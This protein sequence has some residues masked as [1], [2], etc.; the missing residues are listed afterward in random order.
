MKTLKYFLL[1]AI[2]GWLSSCGTGR[3]ITEHETDDVYFS[4]ADFAK[5]ELA[6]A[7]AS[8]N[9]NYDNYVSEQ[10]VPADEAETYRD[11][12]DREP[13]PY[14]DSYG[15]NSSYFASPFGAT[16]GSWYGS[17]YDPWYRPP[18]FSVSIGYGWGGYNAWNNWNRGTVPSPPAGCR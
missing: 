11:R 2:A 13:S 18:G 5:D 4:D 16:Y 8:T 6:N 12:Y 9:D 15:W 7:N 3:M 14:Y 10:E 17:Y 1:V